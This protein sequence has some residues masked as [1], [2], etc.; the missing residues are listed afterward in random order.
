[1]NST[2]YK[3]DSTRFRK[4]ADLCELAA[5]IAEFLESSTPVGSY[6]FALP[7]LLYFSG[8]KALLKLRENPD[9]QALEAEFIAHRGIIGEDWDDWEDS[10][11]VKVLRPV[12]R[13]KS[14][15]IG[16]TVIFIVPAIVG[17]GLGWLYPYKLL[18]KVNCSV[19]RN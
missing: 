15:A 18:P 6:D 11:P 3:K 7:D 14:R 1:M 12:S 8:E 2:R 16:L 9:W 10:K 17:A 4:E 19:V 5:K 13:W